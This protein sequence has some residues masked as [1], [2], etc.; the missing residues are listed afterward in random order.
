MNQ[1]YSASKRLC[2]S[3]V[4]IIFLICCNNRA[5]TQATV[6]IPVGIGKP[7]GGSATNDSLKYFNYNSLSNTLTQ[8]SNCKPNLNFP[9]FSSSLA[10][11]TFNPFDGY[12]YFSQIKRVLGIYSTYTFRWL[13]TICPAAPAPALNSYQFFY[14]QFVAGVEFD[15]ATGLGYQIN[16]VDSTGYPPV[17]TDNATNVGSYSS[18]ATV[19]GFPAM[20]Y[21][22]IGNRDLK[23]VRATDA[24]GINWGTPVTID[25]GGTVGQFTSLTIVNGNPA[26]AYYD[27]T[28]TNLKYVRATDVNGTSWAAPVTVESSAADVGQY[29][30][31]AVVNGNP[32]ISY[33]D[34]TNTDVRYVRSSDVNGAAWGA[35][36]AFA[37]PNSLGMYGSLA[38]VNG[39]PAIS[40]YDNTNGDL[41]YMRST[42]V[43]GAAWSAPI[44]VESANNVGQY[45]SLAIINGNP[46]ISYYD[47]TNQDLRYIRAADASG[48]TW[49]TAA[50]IVAG[51]GNNVGQYTSLRAISG[52]PA[53]SFYDVS[54]QDLRYVRSADANG[55]VWGAGSIAEATGNVGL[56]S[57]LIVANGYP[58]V[59]YQDVS[60]NWAKFVRADD[61]LGTVWYSNTGIS[62]MEL[63]SVNFATGVLGAS[64]P[65]NF[66]S[67]YIYKQNGD[68]VMTPGGQMLASFD[69]K[70]FTV[71]WKDYGT[72]VPLVATYIDTLGFGANNNLVGLSYSGG[73]LVGSIQSTP[74]GT[75]FYREIDILTGAQTPI[76]YSIGGTLF[77][78]ADMT[79]IPSGI[80]AA[81]KLISYVENPVG[82]KT[83]DLVYEV[84]IK[85]YGGTPV[86][87]IQGYDT[88]NN[89]N[90]IGNVISGSISSF[91]APAGITQN[92]SYN[93]KTVFSLLTPGQTLSN[94]PGQNTITLRISARIS[95]INPGI[96]YN[97]QARVTG[98][99]LLGDA[100]Q[101][102]STDGSNPDLN[103]N[104]KPDD[105]GESQPTPL[106]ISIVAQTPPCSTLTNVLYN[107]NF[108][109][110]TG[111]STALPAPTVAAGVLGAT[112][113]TAYAGSTTQPIP[114]ETYTLSSN[115][116]TADNSRWL[117]FAD[118]TGNANG[119][120]LLVNADANN[121]VFYRGRFQYG[122][123][124]KQQYSLSFY[125]AF[126]GNASYQTVCN[127]FGGFQYPKIKMQVIDAVSGGIITSVSTSIISNT[128]WQQYGL[129]FVLPVTYN[130][131]IIELIND[132]PGGCGNDIAIDDIQFGTCD[133]LPVVNVG[134]VAAGCLGSATTFSSSLSD[135]TALPGSKD[136]QWQI[137]TDNVTWVDI[138]LTNSATYT[139]NPITGLDTGKY[140][141][142]VVAATGN[143]SSPYCRYNSPGT[144]L[145][146]KTLS[147]APTSA[148]KDKNNICPGKAV[149]LTVSGGSLGTNA[150][151]KWY[152][153]S[154]TG[155]LVGTGASISVTPNAATTYYVQ[156]EGDCNTTSCQS[157]TVFISCDIDKDKDGI[158]DYI[159]SYIPAAIANGF[160]TSYPGYKDNNNDF[161]NDDFQADG[162]SDADGIPNYL[163]TDFPGR[164]DSNA[165]GVDDRFDF[166]K[167]GIINMLDLDSD[168]D[169]IPD[170]IEAGGVD[171]NGDG[172]I[173]NFTDTDGDGLSQNV[174]GN[175]SGANVSGVGLGALDTDGDGFPN[176]ID[177]DSDNDGIPDVVEVGGAYS[178][179]NGLLS[180]FV[181]ANA[182]GISDNV[183]LASALLKS[184]A[185]INSDGKADSYPNKNL[186]QDKLANPYDLDSDGDGI[187]D[188]LEA[189][190]ADTDFNGKV[191]GAIGSTT[192]WST[193]V[194][195]L[196]SLNLRNTDG[197]GN[198]DYLDIDSD[199]DGIPDNI[200]GQTTAS[201]KF[202]S[203]I[204]AD[205]DGIDDAYDIF[206]G[207]GG[208]GVFLSDK[209]VDGIPDYRDLD[210]DSDGALD[211]YEGNDFNLNGLGDDNVTLTLLDTDGDG[212]DNRF[213]S[214]NSTTNL[215]G[216]SYNMGTGG[217][218]VGDAAPGARCPVQKF[219]PAQ[220]DRDW[221]YT[222][223]VLAVRQFNLSAVSNNDNVSLNWNI[224]STIAVDRFEIQRSTDNINFFT[225]ET[226]VKDVPLNT[227]SNYFSSDAIAKMNN[228]Y[229]FY[230]MKVVNKSGQVSYSNVVVIKKTIVR[231]VAVSVHPNPASDYVM[232]NF[233]SDKDYE[234]TIRLVDNLGK[235]LLVQKHKVSKGE[236]SLPISS[237]SRFSSGT[238]IL[239][240]VMDDQVVTRKLII[241]NK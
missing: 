42:D 218:T 9:G 28:N 164:I 47:V 180:G 220:S 211:I 214:L 112:G 189:G 148:V 24:S 48:A 128:A 50:V 190:F 150:A 67:H 166:D 14:N 233:S 104:D 238:Y 181:D 84:I 5:F 72:A 58:A 80:G 120:M 87:N 143:L 239:Q 13:P 10:T 229:I 43:N 117:T 121:T 91:S 129:K 235:A 64:V 94:R 130:D 140:Y 145:T 55:A 119:K 71:N 122:L 54:N 213:D 19:N 27:V 11:V 52:N 38:V 6:S 151:W 153:G 95:N 171:A 177:L 172:K 156:A 221:R 114:I 77:G 167:D 197:R 3:L 205:K 204:D 192:G 4:I 92:G 62:N 209:D 99:G 234:A 155:T 224:F 90:G 134:S 174:D 207:F 184:G 241:Q 86:V 21:Y 39:N 56:Y 196:A 179:N 206:S 219:N 228:E 208:S 66:G 222:S 188:V 158:P 2:H 212:L 199:D 138:P 35:P 176:A 81:K 70:Y 44:A 124:A 106:L 217:S 25:A 57:S 97:N 178:T 115:P 68:V 23:Y 161:I 60:N 203:G 152:S 223:Y 17:N 170:V 137:S 200:E 118:H 162:D 102:L 146:G 225:I 136:Y 216:S 125:S 26:I 169:G 236:N 135:P 232:I 7:C 185:D 79:N 85:N 142:V 202:P 69:N 141:R 76:T 73:K 157:V 186:D 147:V 45:T 51:A 61:A 30:S 139:I 215:K 20:A 59:C 82:S 149:Q 46:A 12:L 226:Q 18:A 37:S 41:A 187:V 36:V 63:Q 100:L 131:V 8:R 154:C 132:A 182:D 227:L 123:C 193:V 15:P 83:Y 168:N 231:Q 144:K 96:V 126:V 29:A 103:L 201:Y 108:G 110:G 159:E 113:V 195:A 175:T 89:I 98:D 116:Q 75:C 133:A 53:I 33:Y 163:D 16:F 165:D 111:L 230:R 32:A 240:I 237:L 78:S 109:S 191:D 88:L 127:A 173:D 101:D 40:Y 198:P 74:A 49:S 22:D 1:F 34:L 65:I 105:A 183:L 194:D 107:Q 210:T 93:G 160:N 31:L